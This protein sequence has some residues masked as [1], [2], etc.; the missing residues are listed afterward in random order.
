MNSRKG[1]ACLNLAGASAQIWNSEVV[2]HNYEKRN[3][4]KLGHHFTILTCVKRIL[5]I[6][7]ELF[8]QKLVHPKQII[9]LGRL[10]SAVGQVGSFYLLFTK[11]KGVRSLMVP[12]QNIFDINAE[13][14]T[15]PIMKRTLTYCRWRA[16]RFTILEG[17][18]AT[19]V[20]K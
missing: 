10:N 6:S 20:F 2:Y 19:H 1:W 17:L 13:K 7:K 18:T 4:E 12:L 5:L 8:F 11:K 14:I 9:K 16:R 15:V 3:F